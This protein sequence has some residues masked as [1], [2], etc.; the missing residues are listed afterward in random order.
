ME[1][2]TRRV[3]L[4]REGGWGDTWLGTTCAG[5]SASHVSAKHS[6]RGGSAASHETPRARR[7]FPK[8]QRFVAGLLRRAP[9]RYAAGRGRGRRGRGHRGGRAGGAARAPR[10]ALRVMALPLPCTPPLI[11]SFQGHLIGRF[12][13]P[14]IGSFQG[15][16]IGCFQGPLIGSFHVLKGPISWENLHLHPA[17]CQVSQRPGAP[18]TT[19]L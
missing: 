8:P 3:Q 15:P 2:R 12:Q 17:E 7:P 9:R 10:A 19:Q 4:V 1:G 11:G 16:L 18:G 6:V 13:G 5:C 14:L